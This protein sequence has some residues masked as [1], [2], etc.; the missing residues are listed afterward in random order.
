MERPYQSL[1]PLIN[2]RFR[3]FAD[4]ADAALD[5]LADQLPGEIVLGEIEAG[6][7]QMRVRDVRGAAYV[8]I[9]RGQMIPLAAAEPTSGLGPGPQALERTAAGTDELDAAHMRAL[10]LGGWIAV[11]IELSDGAVVGMVA[12]VSRRQ[13]EYRAEHVLMLGLTARILAYEWERVRARTL[14]RELH[15]RIGAGG[16][17]DPDTGLVGRAGFLD[18]LEREWK[19]ARR[20]SLDSMAVCFRVEVDEPAGS[21]LALRALKD[22]AEVLSGLVRS[23][24]LVGRV[25]EAELAMAMV[26]RGDRA[27]VEALAGRFAEVLRRVTHGRDPEAR[28][29]YGAVTLG[30]APS[31][32]AALELAESALA[33]EPIFAGD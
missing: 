4:A 26:G 12:A 15:Q 13:G 33:G 30:D 31:A 7:E 1:Y 27:A 14:I 10:G 20:G 29:A 9:E 2:R 28:V 11:P 23:T 6:A 17:T 19:L 3:S 25:G 32:S 21:P 24:D 22:A 16:D 5:M 18:L 8:G